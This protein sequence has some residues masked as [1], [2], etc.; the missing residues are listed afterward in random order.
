MKVI[1][2]REKEL[3]EGIK[4]AKVPSKII[5][6]ELHIKLIQVFNLLQ[7]QGK[8]K[9]WISCNRWYYDKQ[10]KKQTMKKIVQNCKPVVN[11]E[12]ST[13]ISLNT[14]IKL[15]DFN[16]QNDVYTLPDVLNVKFYLI[17]EDKLQQNNKNVWNE[18][19][20]TR[21]FIGEIFIPFKQCIVNADNDGVFLPED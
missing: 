10:G 9:L 11:P 5:E 4:A 16:K 1:K 19:K 6:G 2:Q 21:S 14:L 12:D 17:P 15:Q 8:P 7:I 3:I 13:Q 18:T 20:E